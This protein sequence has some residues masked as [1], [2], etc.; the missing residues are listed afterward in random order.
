MG[1]TS[2]KRETE[3]YKNKNAKTI[4]TRQKEIPDESCS[5]SYFI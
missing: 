1:D 5:Y 4:S 2:G 3:T